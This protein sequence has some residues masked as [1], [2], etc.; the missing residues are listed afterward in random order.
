MCGLLNT[1]TLISRGQIDL[2]FPGHMIFVFPFVRGGGGD[3]NAESARGGLGVA[4]GGDVFGVALGG[5][6]AGAPI[7]VALGAVVGNT[8]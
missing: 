5:D 8:V 1:S 6:A 2:G 3:E 7:G 4:V